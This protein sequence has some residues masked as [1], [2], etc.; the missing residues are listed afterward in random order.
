[1]RRKTL[2]RLCLGA[3]V[4]AGMALAILVAIDDIAIHLPEATVQEKVAEKMPF[5]AKGIEVTA[6]SV[7][8]GD[9][10]ALI[11]FTMQGTRFGKQYHL[12]ASARGVPEYH[13]D[14]GNLFFKAT[15]V[16]VLDFAYGE[17]NIAAGIKSSRICG[18]TAIASAPLSKGLLRGSRNG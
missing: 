3:L 17:S 13:P 7:K 5:K 10:D 16:K 18:S 9:N 6:A 1:M 11:G 15:D 12:T 14:T 2:A 4:V 8:F